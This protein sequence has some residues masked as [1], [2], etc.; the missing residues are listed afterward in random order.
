MKQSELET[1]KFI[2]KNFRP[3]SVRNEGS[4]EYWERIRQELQAIILLDHARLMET[5]LTYQSKIND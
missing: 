4:I 2:R 1:I 3:R 5:E